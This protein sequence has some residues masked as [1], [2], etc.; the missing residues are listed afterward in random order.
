[1]LV[2]SSLSPQQTK[3]AKE[4]WEAVVEVE[5][6]ITRELNPFSQ[7]K[8]HLCRG[9]ERAATSGSREICGCHPEHNPEP[10]AQQYYMGTTLLEINLGP[11]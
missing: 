8:E 5:A 10:R 4:K 9:T 3:A 7:G 11:N 2:R 6:A 1:M